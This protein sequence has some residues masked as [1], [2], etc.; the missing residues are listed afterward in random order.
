MTERDTSQPPDKGPFFKCGALASISII[1][2]LTISL[3]TTGSIATGLHVTLWILVV[4][5]AL[6]VVLF[7]LGY[8]PGGKHDKPRE[9]P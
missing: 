8:G 5:L 3:L 2:I 1:G 4:L 9:E 7:W 6:I